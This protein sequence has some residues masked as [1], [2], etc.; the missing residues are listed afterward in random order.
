MTFFQKISKK[1]TILSTTIGL[2]I[3]SALPAQAQSSAWQGVCVSDKDADVATLQ[4]LQC[5]LANIL[6]VFLTTIGIAAFLMLVVG[7]FR[8]LISGGN[9]T[10][11]DKAKSSITF[12]IVGLVVA[13]SAFVILN[14][15]AEFTGVQTILNFVIPTSDK[16]W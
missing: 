2:F 3:F 1:I 12:A 14:L 8:L 7:G 11:V 5:L 9:T 6:G 15:V 4:G 13:L 16:Q 10:H